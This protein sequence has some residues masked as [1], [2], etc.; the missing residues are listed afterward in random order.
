MARR[1]VNKDSRLRSTLVRWDPID[2]KYKPYVIDFG[3]C[4]FRGD[5]PTDEEWLYQQ[6]W[7]SEKWEYR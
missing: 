2:N 7:A 6:M 1:T 4:L 3:Q 5:I